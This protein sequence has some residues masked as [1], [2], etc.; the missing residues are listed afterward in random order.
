MK[1]SFFKYS[2]IILFTLLSVTCNKES[3]D[4]PKEIEK[5][6]NVIED[7]TLFPIQNAEISVSYRWS[8]SNLGPFLKVAITDSNGKACTDIID[9]YIVITASVWAQGYEPRNFDVSNFPDVI[10]LTKI[11]E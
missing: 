11:N 2:L 5:C 1:K 7:E 8:E 3:I 6:W 4:A 9:E 10:E